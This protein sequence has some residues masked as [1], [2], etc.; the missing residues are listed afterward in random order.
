M[1]THPMKIVR[2][3]DVFRQLNISSP[4]VSWYYQHQL[5]VKGFYIFHRVS[6]KIN[7]PYF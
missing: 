3:P 7:S 4:A 1:K 2:R 5:E 6:N